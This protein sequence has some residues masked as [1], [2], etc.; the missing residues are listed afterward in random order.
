MHTTEAHNEWKHSRTSSARCT[1]GSLLLHCAVRTPHFHSCWHYESKY[2]AKF[3]LMVIVGCGDL[4]ASNYITQ[5]RI[6]WSSGI[7]IA[8]KPALQWRTLDSL[9]FIPLEELYATGCWCWLLVFMDN[10]CPTI[11]FPQ[12]FICEQPK[13][14]WTHGGQ[15]AC[16]F[17]LPSGRQRVFPNSFLGLLRI[18]WPI[19]MEQ[20]GA[21][22]VV[23]AFIRGGEVHFEP[24]LSPAGT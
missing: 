4:L 19:N 1:N 23:I 5:S 22:K 9:Q 12:P 3:T 10:Q 15:P 16:W 14:A 21:L 13:A 11:M 18:E 17:L 8:H 20:V 6:L 2:S 7:F 24:R